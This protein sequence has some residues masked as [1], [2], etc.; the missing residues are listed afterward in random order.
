[1]LRVTFSILRKS[2]MFNCSFRFYLFVSFSCFVCHIMPESIA[3]L[4]KKNA[5][6][7]YNLLGHCHFREVRIKVDAWTVNWDVKRW[8]L[9]RVRC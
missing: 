8:P 6:F 9:K 2:L 5:Y 1:M 7:D 4:G 3:N